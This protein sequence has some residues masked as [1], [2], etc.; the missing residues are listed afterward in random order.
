M[1]V[2]LG[3]P[4]TDTKGVSCCRLHRGPT[5][6]ASPCKILQLVAHDRGLGPALRQLTGLR[7]L[8]LFDPFQLCDSAPLAAL[9]QLESFTG[10]VEH[11][12]V[13]QLP[14]G[15]TRLEVCSRYVLNA[16]LDVREARQEVDGGG[17]AG[18]RG[19]GRGR[20]G[21]GGTSRG[22]GRQAAGQQQQQ[23]PQL[24]HVYPQLQ[25]LHLTAVDAQSMP[26]HE[27]SR[28]LAAFQ[29]AFGSS[30]RR[31]GLRVAMSE[32]KGKAEADATKHHARI[33]PNNQAAYVTPWRPQNFEVLAGLVGLQE[34]LVLRPWE[35]A[36]QAL[37]QLGALTRLRFYAS[38]SKT[39]LKHVVQLAV[40]LPQLRR[41][42][43]W[44][45]WPQA[46]AK[47][48]IQALPGCT[49]DTLWMEEEVLGDGEEASTLY[50]A[51]I[52]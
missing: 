35:G 19:R 12:D 9:A 24:A 32:V 27:Q 26:R 45:D 49:L 28:V 23:Q 52:W 25:H 10:T 1:H 21:G 5:A 40:G 13:A 51:G 44:D 34:L 30:L 3:W 48:L 47:R 15:L 39:E 2:L 4:L 38:L 29:P 41:L 7:H 36:G 14:P 16:E 20:G 50:G 22:R 6:S 31:L 8:V 33:R 18:S 42:G 11:L 43:L 46:A 37:A 17:M